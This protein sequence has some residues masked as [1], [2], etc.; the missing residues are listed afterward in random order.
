MRFRESE[1]LVVR[2]NNSKNGP[3][4]ISKKVS[5]QKKEKEL[6][7]NLKCLKEPIYKREKK[8]SQGRS[9]INSL[10]SDH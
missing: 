4:Q 1:V 3:P 8:K 10:D 9:Q 7:R 2:R 6:R 5:K